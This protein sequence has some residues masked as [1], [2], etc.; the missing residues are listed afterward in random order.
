VKST[1]KHEA[2]PE[3]QLCDA[4]APCQAC[5]ALVLV[6]VSYHREGVRELAEAQ[7]CVT[8]ERHVCQEKEA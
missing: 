6:R 8:G 4:F 5:G 3:F 7:S 1:V 2:R